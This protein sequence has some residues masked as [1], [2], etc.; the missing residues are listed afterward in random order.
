LTDREAVYPREQYIAQTGSGPD[1]E[2]AETAGARAIARFF[3]SSITARTR[4]EASSVNYGATESV[5]TET[6]FIDTQIE[7]F[8]LRYDS[9]YDKAAKQWEAAAYIDRAEAGEIYEPRIR[10][11]EA[12]FLPLYQAARDESD[13]IRRYTLC[14]RAQ[15]QYAKHIAPLLKF[16]ELL[17]PRTARERF[18]DTAAALAE[19]PGMART[20]LAQSTVY[21]RSE[22]DYENL[23]RR[24]GEKALAAEGFPVT[25]SEAA[26]TLAITIH[27]NMSESTQRGRTMFVFETALLAEL[28]GADGVVFSF[29]TG[30]PQ[31]VV[32]MTREAG[33]RRAYAALAETVADTFSARLQQYF[34]GE[35]IP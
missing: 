12:A 16:A 11:Q 23:L 7:L 13:P 22:G 28:G 1:R 15:Y 10:A 4:E 8:A 5:I 2:S 25:A 24:A 18:P 33:Q 27:E 17:H 30:L 32:A 3:S 26:G 20:A 35:S 19:L 6:T 34:E 14:R 31:R 9:W 29:E 21:V